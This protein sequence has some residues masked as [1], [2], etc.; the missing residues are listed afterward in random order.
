L[1]WDVQAGK[2][3]QHL[4]SIVAQIPSYSVYCQAFLANR[5]VAE[6]VGLKKLEIWYGRKRRTVWHSKRPSDVSDTLE[7]VLDNNPILQT[8]EVGGIVVRDLPIVAIAILGN[9]RILKL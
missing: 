9:L 7:L 5:R 4:R 1:P 2:I 3:R 6:L 8:L